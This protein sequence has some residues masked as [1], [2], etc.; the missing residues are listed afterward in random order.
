M[1]IKTLIDVIER[2]D[3]V[4]EYVCFI[5]E[6][7]YTDSWYNGI[8]CREIHMP[9]YGIL[10]EGFEDLFTVNNCGSILKEY[11][12]EGFSIELTYDKYSDRYDI[13]IRKFDEDIMNE[14]EEV[15]EEEYTDPLQNYIKYLEMLSKGC[16]I[17]INDQDSAYFEKQ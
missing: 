13:I 15:T 9:E 12:S 5:K 8:R 7:Y 10:F 14:M 17:I 2:L 3:H 4:S 16:K 1:E 6:N 11:K